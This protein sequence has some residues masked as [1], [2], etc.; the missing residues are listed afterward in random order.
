M[1]LYVSDNFCKIK[2][3]DHYVLLGAVAVEVVHPDGGEPVAI[4]HH[5]H[6]LVQWISYIF[7][8]V[9]FYMVD[10]YT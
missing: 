9:T 2:T 3:T 8:M 5:Q 7:H 10:F 6:Q 4:P 1:L